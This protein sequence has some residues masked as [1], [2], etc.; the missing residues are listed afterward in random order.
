MK[1]GRVEQRKEMRSILDELII[2]PKDGLKADLL[3]LKEKYSN[4]HVEEKK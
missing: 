3:E 4:F 2:R 1:V